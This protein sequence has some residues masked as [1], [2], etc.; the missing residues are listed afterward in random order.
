MKKLLMLLIIIW[1]IVSFSSNGLAQER[2]IQTLLTV[3]ELDGVFH[4]EREEKF[5]LYFLKNE[6]VS[7]D[8]HLEYHGHAL[9]MVDDTTGT[10]SNYIEVLELKK[11]NDE[12]AISIYYKYH[13][14][15]ITGVLE[16][17]KQGYHVLTYDIILK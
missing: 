9:I 2:A 5:P 8:I 14:A 15:E 7:G 6:I 12:V 11:Q 16:G 10:Q 1:C 17:S 3:P 13:E 4:P